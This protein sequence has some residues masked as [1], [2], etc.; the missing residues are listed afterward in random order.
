MIKEIKY[1]IYIFTIFFFIF[2]SL[3]YYFSE[4]NKKNYFLSLNLIDEK[5]KQNEINMIILPSDTE[6]IIEYNNENLN[7]KNNDY[8]FWNLL[9]KN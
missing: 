7:E 5:I 9:K 8:K 1:L 4:D 6:N 2:F 3:R